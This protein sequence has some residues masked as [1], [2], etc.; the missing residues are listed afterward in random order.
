MSIEWRNWIPPRTFGEKK[1]AI[2][3][4]STLTNRQTEY[5]YHKLSQMLEELCRADAH[6]SSIYFFVLFDFLL[7]KKTIFNWKH[8]LFFWIQKRKWSLDS[9]LSQ[10]APAISFFLGGAE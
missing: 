8:S 1:N 10:E 3:G 5:P 7:E 6:T 2:I 9:C 4:E